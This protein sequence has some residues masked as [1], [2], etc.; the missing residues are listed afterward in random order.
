[1]IGIS[2]RMS[3]GNYRR[4]LG[5]AATCIL[6]APSSRAADQASQSTAIA[7][8]EPLEEV[9]VYARRRP[10]RLE[11]VPA[12]VTALNRS[13]FWQRRKSLVGLSESLERLDRCMASFT[14]LGIN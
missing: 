12:A 9:I 2:G 4:I 8:S 11:D 7:D 10:E 5:L 14:L 13:I 6:L 1:M 3:N